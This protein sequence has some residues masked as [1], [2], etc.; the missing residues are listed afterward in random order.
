[1]PVKSIHLEVQNA[2][3]VGLLLLVFMRATDLPLLLV[4]IADATIVLPIFV[5]RIYCCHN[6]CVVGYVSVLH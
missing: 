1:M 4:I 3:W 6:D 2:S 5:T